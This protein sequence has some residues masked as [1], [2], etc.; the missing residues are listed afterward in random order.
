M[1]SSRPTFGQWLRISGTDILLMACLGAIGLGI[2][3][4]PPGPTRSFPIQF[5]YSDIVYPQFAYPLRKEIIPIWLSSLLSV[6]IPVFF[7]SIAQS[8][9]RSFADLNTATFGLLQSLITAAVFQ[10]FLKWLIGGLR[11][12]FLAV[13]KPDLRYSF[14]VTALNPAKSRLVRGF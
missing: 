13:C 8:R 10:V 14:V 11:P 5:Q 1:G 9:I 12:H 4:A 7:F 3:K 6:I 2:Y